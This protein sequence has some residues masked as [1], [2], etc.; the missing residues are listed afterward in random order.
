MEQAVLHHLPLPFLPS[1]SCALQERF[2]LPCAPL[3]CLAHSSSY[4]QCCSRCKAP[5]STSGELQWRVEIPAVRPVQWE[6]K[7]LKVTFPRQCLRLIAQCPDSLFQNWQSRSFQDLRFVNDQI[8]D[9]G[10][11]VYAY[12][13]L[14]LFLTDPNYDHLSPEWEDQ[15]FYVPVRGD[16][17]C[18]LFVII[19]IIYVLGY[20]HP[21]GLPPPPTWSPSTDTMK[22][23]RP[24]TTA[25]RKALQFHVVMFLNDPQVKENYPEDLGYDS[26]CQE[27]HNLFRPDK[28]Y[29]AYT[30]PPDPADWKWD[31]FFFLPSALPIVAGLFNLRLVLYSQDTVDVYDAT[32]KGSLRYLTGPKAHYQPNCNDMST[33]HILGDGNHYDL[34]IPFGRVFPKDEHLNNGFVEAL[35]KY[36]EGMQQPPRPQKPHPATHHLH[37][38]HP[39]LP[40]PLPLTP[41]PQRTASSQMTYPRPR[42]RTNALRMSP[43][44]LPLLPASPSV[45]V[46]SCG[47]ESIPHLLSLLSSSLFSTHCTLH[48][49]PL[50]CLHPAAFIY[51]YFTFLLYYFS[52]LSP[53]YSCL[54][55]SFLGGDRSSRWLCV[56]S[57]GVVY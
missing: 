4:K 38:Y 40:S 39:P 45:A 28:N 48:L 44:P 46:D 53:L 49:H 17:R 21:P 8:E 42:I 55:I 23:E 5:R 50:P 22:Q 41:P 56:A 51:V 14:H 24:Y 3:S 31:M 12:D 20:S 2:N 35:K 18:A 36:Q 37:R 26:A 30:A 19:A 57:V 47:S 1:L 9:D 32:S 6:T 34:V 7:I 52:A 10:L 54:Q 11:L 43:H 16:S 33:F 25:L 27:A 15:W 13:M 29:D